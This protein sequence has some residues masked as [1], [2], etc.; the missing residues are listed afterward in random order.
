MDGLKSVNHSQDEYVRGE[1]HTSNIESFWALLKRGVVGTFQQV[2]KTYLLLY[3]A[4]FPSATIT[5]I[6]RIYYGPS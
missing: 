1:V 3:L 2:G 6:I 4:E 5:A